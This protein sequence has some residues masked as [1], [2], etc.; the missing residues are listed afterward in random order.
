MSSKV[1]SAIAGT[2]F[3]PKEIACFRALQLI[4]RYLKILDPDGANN[5]SINRIG[6]QQTLQIVLK[7][8]Y[9]RLRKMKAN[10][11]NFSKG[12]YSIAS[13]TNVLTGLFQSGMSTSSLLSSL[14][15]LAGVGFHAKS[16]ILEMASQHKNVH[17]VSKHAVNRTVAGLSFVQNLVL[18]MWLLAAFASNISTQTTKEEIQGVYIIGVYLVTFIKIFLERI[19]APT[20]K[21]IMKK[22]YINSTNLQNGIICA[23]IVEDA[24]A[25]VQNS[26]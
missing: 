3:I 20:I 2:S 13:R 10:T 26:K 14:I 24:Y 11:V 5:Y 15:S 8:L 17:N 18:L 4:G 19:F 21:V 1:I 16:I 7:G 22:S 6:L 12:S 23:N 9:S 25:K